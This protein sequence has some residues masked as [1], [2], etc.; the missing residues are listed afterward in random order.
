MSTDANLTT[1]HPTE[2]VHWTD[3]LR[4]REWKN[5]MLDSAVDGGGGS[6]LA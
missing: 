2:K 3:M 5:R 4:I 6:W 1:N